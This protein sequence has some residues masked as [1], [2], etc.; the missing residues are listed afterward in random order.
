[1]LHFA[2]QHRN[3]FISK[4]LIMNR[5]TFTLLGLSLIILAACNKVGNKPVHPVDPDNGKQLTLSA[6]EKQNVTAD[7]SFALKLFKATLPGTDDNKN[8]ML[9]PL[10]VSMAFGMTSNGAANQTLKDIRS[11]MNFGNFTEEELNDYY[12]K[13]LTELPGLEPNTTIKIAN[14]IWYTNTFTPI[15]AFLQVNNDKYNAKIASADFKSPAAVDA[16]NSWVNTATN[17][18]IPTIIETIPDNAVMYLINAIYFKSA[19]ANK[20]DASKTQKANFRLKSGD[21]IPAD[22]MSSEIGLNANYSA[23][24]TVAEL[25]YANNKF[26]MVIILPANKTVKEYAATLDPAKWQSL[27]SGLLPTKSLVMLPRFKFSFDINMN[28]ILKGMGMA[29]AFSNQADF[30]RI[31]AAGHLAITDV[32]HKTFIDV[33]EDGTEAAAVTSIGIGTTSVNPNTFRFDRPFI[34]AIREKKTGLILFTGVV[35]D[36]TK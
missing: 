9:S 33:N 17:N 29:S 11:T 21:I 35:N 22:M 7:N 31:N 2:K 20:F 25:P 10:S 24:A 13:L 15:P 6:A 8:M 36:P 18:K 14:S 23:D 26:S 34:F 3:V 16:I 1:M 12:A 32:K 30:T 28:D 5:K 4:L 19:W 27:M